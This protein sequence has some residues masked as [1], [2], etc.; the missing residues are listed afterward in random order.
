[1]AEISSGESFFSPAV[2]VIEMYG[3]PFYETILYGTYFMS[4]YTSLSSN[5]LP[6]SL[7]T[8]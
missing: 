8:T 2:V 6:T 5:C 1:M 4:L 7:L 3:F